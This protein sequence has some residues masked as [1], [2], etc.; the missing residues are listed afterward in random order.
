MPKNKICIFNNNWLTSSKYSSWLVKSNCKSKARCK[1]CCK[2]FDISNMGVSA[3]ESHASGKKHTDIVEKRSS[4]T[5]NLFF[6]NTTVQPVQ[7]HPA[8]TST[9]TIEC[10]VIPV[11]ASYAEILWSLKVVMSHFSLRSCLELNE[12]F[13]CMFSD[14]EIAKSF[15]L[16]KTKCSYY[17][18]HGLAPYFKEELVKSINLSSYIVISFDESMNRVIQDEQMD[19]NI[20]YWDDE[21]GLVVTRYFGSQFL[22]RPNAENLF[23]HLLESMKLLSP[24]WLIQLSMDGPNTNWEVLRL[25]DEHRNEKEWP[26]II[27]IGSCGLHIVHGAFQTG[28][29]ATQWDLAKIMKSMW[30]MFHDSPARRDVYVRICEKEEFPLRYLVVL[31]NW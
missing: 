21:K 6:H 16:S 28:V 14:S 23:K 17:I 27:N 26:S 11:S 8:P 9:Q 22:R 24:K 15:R 10:M 12:L 7:P 20:R 18:N 29:Q 13:K 4:G 2:D 25:L 19:L 1:L 3:L 30:Q 5:G 31:I